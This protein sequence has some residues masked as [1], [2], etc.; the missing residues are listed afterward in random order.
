MPNAFQVD[1]GL[2]RSAATSVDGCCRQIESGRMSDAF[3]EVSSG[4]AGFAVV[5]ACESACET[6]GTAFSGVARSWRAWSEAAS[7]GADQ[8]ERLDSG[9]EA[10]LRGV[11][12][13]LVV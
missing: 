7:S 6:S 8:Y 10:L 3:G 11:G 2:L 5:A 4:M 9:G 12:S 13:D 1:S